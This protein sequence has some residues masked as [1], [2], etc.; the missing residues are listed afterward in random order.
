MTP[1]L[2]IRASK[3][4]SSVT[5]IAAFS[6]DSRLVRSSGIQLTSASGFIVFISDI[7]TFAFSSERHPNRTLAFLLARTRAAS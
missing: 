2:F 4:S 7:A 3:C 5:I 1:A 6:I